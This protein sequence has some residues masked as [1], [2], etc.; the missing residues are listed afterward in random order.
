M[1]LWTVTR[2]LPLPA[3]VCD[4]RRRRVSTVCN[5]VR[6]RSTP[7]RP[8]AG[9]PKLLIRCPEPPWGA[10]QGRIITTLHRQ[11]WHHGPLPRRCGGR[12]VGVI[13]PVCDDD[14][15]AWARAGQPWPG[16]PSPLPAVPS[17][18]QPRS[19]LRCHY[20]LRRHRI[21]IKSVRDGGNIL[22]LG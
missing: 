20:N 7:V 12:G 14:P 19:G 17:E 13:H 15:G 21:P 9:A 4:P 3:S 16:L 10:D 8:D 2:V 22:V 18:V 5:L 6:S 1:H 11:D